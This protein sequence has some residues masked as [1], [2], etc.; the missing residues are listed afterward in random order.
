M[1]D[2]ILFTLLRPG[3]ISTVGEAENNEERQAAPKT[4]ENAKN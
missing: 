1:L 3:K 2:E 4:G